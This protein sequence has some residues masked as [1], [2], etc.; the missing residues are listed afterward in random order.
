MEKLNLSEKFELKFNRA[1]PPM[2]NAKDS[3][4]EAAL[5][6]ITG[7]G[8]RTVDFA[9]DGG[10]LTQMGIE[11]FV[12]GAGDLAQAHMPD[13]YISLDDFLRGSSYVEEIIRKLLF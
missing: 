4:L 11:C 2:P 9:T 10:H 3:E 1:S 12:C 8:L 5:K 13:E 7:Q 6:E